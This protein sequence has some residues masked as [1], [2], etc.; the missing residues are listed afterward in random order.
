MSAI[1]IA[2]RPRPG[3]QR[4]FRSKT[5]SLLTD[6]LERGQLLPQGALVPTSA[7]TIFYGYNNNN[8]SG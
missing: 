1:M 2:G 5:G 6:G 7:P 3:G 8:A 4:D